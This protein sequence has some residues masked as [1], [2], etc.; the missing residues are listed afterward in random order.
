MSLKPY[1]KLLCLGV[2]E[3]RSAALHDAQ[4]RHAVPVQFGPS[5]ADARERHA[6]KFVPGRNLA[7]RHVRFRSGAVIVGGRRVANDPGRSCAQNRVDRS[8]ESFDHLVSATKQRFWKCD[9]ERP[10]GFHVDDQFDAGGLLNRQISRLLPL[11]NSARVDT[12]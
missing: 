4:R 8:R 10:R 2:P 11:E 5:P 9:A 1:C 3:I 6:V 7:S 12:H